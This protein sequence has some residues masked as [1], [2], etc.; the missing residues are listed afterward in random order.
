MSILSNMD[1]PTIDVD[2][3]P[4]KIEDEKQGGP[5]LH[6]DL[7]DTEVVHKLAQMF[8]PGLGSACV[9]NTSG[10]LFKTPGAVAVDLR[11]EM[12]EYLTQ[13][14]ESFVAESVILE[15]GP[16]GE[17]SDHPFDIISNFVDDFVG[18]KRNFFS[19]VSAWLLSDMRED[20]I[21]D[22]VQEMEMNGFWT[23]ERRETIAETLLKNVDFE[24][25][26]HC[27][28]SFNSAEELANHIDNC[29][30]RSMICENEGCNSRFCASHLKKHDSTCP[31]KI[32]QCEQK[33]SDNIMRRE[34]DRHCITVCPMKLVNCP[35]YSVG[36]R[37]AVAQCLIEKHRLDDVDSHLWHM[38]KGI[39][40]QAYGDDLKRR[41]EQIVQAS[42]RSRLAEARD[43]RSL[44]FIVKD[45]EAKLGPFEVSAVQ[46]N[47]AET[48]AKN[49]D[50]EGGETDMNASEN[51]TKAS[52]TVNSSDKAEAS[53]MVN[54]NNA[55]NTAKNEDTEPS[56]VEKKDSE[57]R[58][59]TSNMANLSD[60]TET[61][62]LNDETKDTAASES[63]IKGDE[64]STQTQKQEL[65]NE[66]VSATNEGSAENSIKDKSNEDSKF[67]DKDDEQ[68]IQK[69]KMEIKDDAEN[70]VKGKEI[71]DDNLKKNIDSAEV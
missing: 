8:L 12:I 63:K 51:S 61:G 41:V 14:S 58:T 39:H 17:V 1:M 30:F 62:P 36:C 21:D 2:L 66:E 6:C 56:H 44:N 9:D 52:D 43:V 71:E 22:F 37:S 53:D 28:M 25:S 7:C 23:L 48:V 50:S 15:G 45:I 60:T 59:Q 10:G 32:I 55:E 31:F 40:K 26:Y 18:L 5:L 27:N 49:G 65:S 29:N 70:N 4:E 13:R 68:S 35:F 54:K 42:S 38:L 57:E 19:R 46:K 16:D 47:S 67:E 11:K 24:N 20:K 64:E 3:G 33:C 69:S 34:M